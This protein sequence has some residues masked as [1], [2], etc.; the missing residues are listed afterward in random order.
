MGLDFSRELILDR[1]AD[2]IISVEGFI[3]V[4]NLLL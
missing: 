2:Y 3:D 4:S 1:A